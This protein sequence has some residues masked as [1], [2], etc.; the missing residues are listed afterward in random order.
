[1]IGFMAILPIISLAD[2]ECKYFVCDEWVSDTCLYIE[3]SV[4]VY[5][6]CLGNTYCPDFTFN[7]TSNVYCKTGEEEGTSKNSCF[8]YAKKDKEC[9]DTKICVPGYYCNEG[10]CSEAVSKDSQKKSCKTRGCG[11]GLVCNNE[12][13]TNY[14][15]LSE[16]SPATTKY[17]CASGRLA[18]GVCLASDKS[19]HIPM[20]CSNDDN[21]KGTANITTACRCTRDEIPKKYCEL[22]ESDDMVI[23]AM[24]ATSDKYFE[25]ADYLWYQVKNYPILEYSTRCHK[26][27]S[28]EIK[29]YEKLKKIKEKCYDSA[30][31]LAFSVILA[32]LILA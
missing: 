25:L 19:P 7:L 30:A 18:G 2:E 3:D 26:N 32:L 13:C 9:N 1:M 17:A 5:T 22:H 14:F 12:T 27:D 6:P 24:K 29:Y 16:G 10:I 11:I 15:S 21:C 4:A 8:K 20:E 28:V 31:G 23:E